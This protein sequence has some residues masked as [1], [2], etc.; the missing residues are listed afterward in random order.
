LEGFSS[1]LGYN[2][3]DFFYDSTKGTFHPLIE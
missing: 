3:C 2:F 1:N